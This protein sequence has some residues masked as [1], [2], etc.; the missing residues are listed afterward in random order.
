MMFQYSLVEHLNAA[1]GGTAAVQRYYDRKPEILE[2]HQ[3][4]GRAESISRTGEELLAS[5]KLAIQ[6]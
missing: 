2:R 1:E 6:R 3:L 5:L 4:F